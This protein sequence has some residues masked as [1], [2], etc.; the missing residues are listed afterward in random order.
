MWTKY[1]G[2]LIDELLRIDP[3]TLAPDDLLSYAHE[4]RSRVIKA[5]DVTDNV[6]EVL[7]VWEE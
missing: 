2:S 3:D 5:K 7:D 1:S 4:L 6:R